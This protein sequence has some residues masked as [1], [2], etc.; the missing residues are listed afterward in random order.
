MPG[1]LGIQ[2]S[3]ERTL[4]L[5][6]LGRLGGCW[7]DWENSDHIPIWSIEE[8]QFNKRLLYSPKASSSGNST[9][10]LG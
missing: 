5:E 8:P 6:A 3:S 1:S 2:Q 4:G 10:V 7:L 9:L